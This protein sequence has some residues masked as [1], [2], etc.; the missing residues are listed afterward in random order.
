MSG[1]I[2]NIRIICVHSLRLV[3]WKGLDF[4]D[5]IYLLAELLDFLVHVLEVI[6]TEAG[7]LRLK[8]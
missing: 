5:D 2:I 6:A 8:L 3:L 1:W 7:S 4:A